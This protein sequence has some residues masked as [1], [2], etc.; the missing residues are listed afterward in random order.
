M[1]DKSHNLLIVDDEKNVLNSLKRLLQKEGYRIFTAASGK[2]GLEI[3]KRETI[4]VV[5]S[6]LMMPEMDGVAFLENASEINPDAIQI[7]LTGYA[8]LNTAVE[9]INRLGLF[10]FIVKPWKNDVIKSD[11]GRAFDKFQL[12]RE[13]KRLYRLTMEQNSKL[14][15][16]NE[17]LEDRVKNRTQLLEEA[18][19]ETIF[20]LAQI[21]EAKDHDADDGHIYR[22]RILVFDLCKALQMNDEEA[23]RISKFSMIHDLGKVNVN[24]AV[25]NK[26]FPLTKTE[27][28][29]LQSHTVAGEALLGV[30]PFY[31]TA[32]EIV[33]GHHENWDGTGY[34]D[35][36][37]QKEIP[38][39]AR[40][41]AVADAFDILTHGKK[42]QDRPTLVKALKTIGADA[43]RKFDPKIAEVF[44]KLQT[45][46]ISRKKQKTGPEARAA[47][48]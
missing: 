12:I 16:W 46:R 34:P 7:L 23:D 40:I 36:L 43:G 4:G 25:L 26:Q 11:I 20:I 18:I 41:V 3:I 33:R 14:A 38:L 13:N 47:N 45:K 9:A 39:A 5:I 44:I 22:V 10:G 42:K 30:K 35:R 24:D 29:E 27:R 2:E 32:R 37:Q 6:D 48:F 21:A 31:Q 28:Q 15:D 19:D 8:S 17:T 1:A